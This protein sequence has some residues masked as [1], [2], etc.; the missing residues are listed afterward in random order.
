LWNK[1]RTALHDE[2]KPE[3]ADPNTL[4]FGYKY[5]ARVGVWNNSA[6]VIVGY[7]VREHPSPEEKG[8]EYFLAFSYDL[9]S[10]LLS[11]IENPEHTDVDGLYMWHWKFAKLARFE[12]SPVPDVVFTYLTCWECEEETIL[13]A[14]RYDLAN[15][16]WKIRNFG[17]G[18]PKWWM[19]RVGVVVGRDVNDGGDTISYDCLYRIFDAG[20]DGFGSIAMRCREITESLPGK[21]EVDDSTVLYTVH[22]NSFTGSIV[23]ANDERSKI[24]SE[25]CRTNPRSKLCR[26]SAS[27]N[28]TAIGSH[29][30]APGPKALE[31]ISSMPVGDTL[32]APP[33]Q[34]LLWQRQQH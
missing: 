2:L 15:H 29:T 16:K 1:V 14:L 33:P 22:G 23:W 28:G 3:R 32:Q 8:E 19:T 21:T 31:P 7:R 6:L 5:L 4:T 34:P 17:N 9:A 25:L 11:K 18:I 10:G 12:N 24:W 20:D 26:E 27:S 13:S 30:P